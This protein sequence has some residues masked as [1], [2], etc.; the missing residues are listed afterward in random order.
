[1]K[2]PTTALITKCVFCETMQPKRSV[3][4]YCGKAICSDCGANLWDL[5]V[6]GDFI[7]KEAD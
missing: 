6:R 5:L 7:E 1:M 2:R 4:F 3:V